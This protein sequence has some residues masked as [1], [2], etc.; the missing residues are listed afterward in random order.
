MKLSHVSIRCADLNKSLE[1]YTKFF[2]T[3]VAHT[4]EDINKNPYGYFLRLPKGGLIEL[5]Q[6]DQEMSSACKN[7]LNHYCIEVDSIDELLGKMERESIYKHKFRGRTDNILQAAIL[8]PDGV[9]IELH[10]LDECSKFQAY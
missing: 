8:D 6:S 4:F 9:I 5:F 3:A 10:E 1:Y 2:Y 7:P